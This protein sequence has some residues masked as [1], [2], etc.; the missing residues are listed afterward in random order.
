MKKVKVLEYTIVFSA[1]FGIFLFAYDAV[2]TQ[3]AALTMERDSLK[4]LKNVV[5]E[6][7]EYH[8]DR[9]SNKCRVLDREAGLELFQA[10]LS[11]S[12]TLGPSKAKKIQDKIIRFT[13]NYFPNKS[14]RICYIAVVFESLPNK[15]Y[16]SSFLGNQE[17]NEIVARQGGVLV[18][19][20]KN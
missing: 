15:M 18:A 7:C 16:F 12:P 4:G 13:G 6:A 5:V 19:D 2:S 10:F 9:I 20:I 3:N 17:C 1:I 14:S 11:S 8:G